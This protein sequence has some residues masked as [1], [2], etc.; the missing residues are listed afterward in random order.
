MSPIIRRRRGGGGQRRTRAHFLVIGDPIDGA[1]LTLQMRAN[2]VRHI[3]SPG[4]DN[5]RTDETLRERE[6]AAS[7]RGGDDDRML[8]GLILMQRALPVSLA[9]G[10]TAVRRF[11]PPGRGTA[12]G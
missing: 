4:S 11:M 2:F 7:E 12:D 8:L 1:D 6:N 10:L 5:D 3:S 9:F